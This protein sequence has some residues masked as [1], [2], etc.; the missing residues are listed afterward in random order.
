MGSKNLNLKN[1]FKQKI[2]NSKS[3]HYK[4]NHKI[5][6]LVGVYEKREKTRSNKNPDT[7]S[8]KKNNVNKKVLFL[9]E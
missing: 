2:K 8:N 1:K 7:K 3:T 5:S 6:S 4:K 9:D